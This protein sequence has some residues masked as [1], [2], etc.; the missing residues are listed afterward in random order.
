MQKVTSISVLVILAS[1]FTVSLFAHENCGM[2]RI[3]ENASH[4]GMKMAEM[5]C[6][7]GSQE[8]V[9]V[10]IHLVASAPL[11]KVDVQKDVTSTLLN[12]QNFDILIELEFNFIELTSNLSPPDI[13]SG[14]LTPLLV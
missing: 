8:C 3:T 7:A 5:D 1:F 4:C 13:F 11:N 14:F 12:D 10:A 9:T 6:C 2:I